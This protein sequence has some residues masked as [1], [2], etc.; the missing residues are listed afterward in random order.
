M[1]K[2]L[3]MVKLKRM[4]H[5]L[6]ATESAMIWANSNEGILNKLW[7][8]INNVKTSIEEQE[9]E[10]ARSRKSKGETYIPK[11]FV[12]S[13]C[14]ETDELSLFNRLNCNLLIVRGKW[15]SWCIHR[16]SFVSCVALLVMF[17]V[18]HIQFARS[19]KYNCFSAY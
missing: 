15:D 17:F 12:L 9:R 7:N 13:D 2:D 19:S 4:N 14:K 18:C 3:L 10:V 11:H 16:Y 1:I 5:R 8:K 6:W